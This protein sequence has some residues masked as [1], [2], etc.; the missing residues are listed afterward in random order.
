MFLFILLTFKALSHFAGS[1][2]VDESRKKPASVH[3]YILTNALI[4]NRLHKKRKIPHFACSLQQKPEAH[5]T[6]HAQM[7][8]VVGAHRY[9]NRNFRAQGIFVYFI[10]IQ[11][12]IPLCGVKICG[13]EQEKTSQRFAGS[14]FVDESRKKPAS[15]HSY[16]LTNAF[17]FNNLRKK[18]SHFVCPPLQKA[19]VQDTGYAR[20]Q[21]SCVPAATKTESNGH[22]ACLTCGRFCVY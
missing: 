10:D 6:G 16:I 19:G 5:A 4:F 20:C 2:F 13:R 18:I 14:K 3:N 11:Y 7:P 21:M 9:K 1:K 8:D 22:E 12:I 15:A 17:I